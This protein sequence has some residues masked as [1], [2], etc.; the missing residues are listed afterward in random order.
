MTAFSC[1]AGP[2][3]SLG[4]RGP[5]AALARNT[6]LQGL[7]SLPPFTQPS[8]TGVRTISSRKKVGTRPPLFVRFALDIVSAPPVFLQARALP[9][10]R[11]LSSSALF[12]T[13][14]FAVFPLFLSSC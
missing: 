1:A 6:R 14:A 12:A 8:P 11:V 5:F 7:S 3:T 4:D 13:F 2:R 10:L 9:I